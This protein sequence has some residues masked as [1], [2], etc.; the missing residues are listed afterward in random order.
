MENALK[1]II[2]KYPNALE[3]DKKLKAFLKDYMPEN[4]LMQNMLMMVYD[5]G[6]VTDI[7]HKNKLD[8]FRMY[9]YIKCLVNEYGIT[10]KA[11]NNVIEQW[12]TALDIEFEEV[13]VQEE[14]VKKVKK[15]G[16]VID[17]SDMSID[18][19]EITGKIIRI[20]GEGQKVIPNVA[21]KDGTYIV[22]AKNCYALLFD[23]MGEFRIIVDAEDE[24]YKEDMFQTG[25]LK[26]NKPG[27][28]KIQSDGEWELELIPM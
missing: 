2:T 26:M 13:T 15:T 14:S 16:D 28:V 9:G 11:A 18:D 12:A 24:P 22:K 27:I 20:A 6:I 5:S 25:Y 3:D 17:Y 7:R 4:K 1:E 10:E 19:F 8:K 21:I 23:A